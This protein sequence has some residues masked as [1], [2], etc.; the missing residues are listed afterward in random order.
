MQHVT[1]SLTQKQSYLVVEAEG[2]SEEEEEEEGGG[3]G[4]RLSI[5][6]RT[7]KR[8]IIESYLLHIDVYTYK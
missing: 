6:A 8:S 3:E 5:M 1:K 4:G 2:R 7:S